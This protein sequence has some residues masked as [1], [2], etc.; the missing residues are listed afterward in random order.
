M[1]RPGVSKSP[2][3]EALLMFCLL[4]GEAQEAAEAVRFRHATCDRF[5]RC[6]LSR[7]L[8]DAPPALRR[9]TLPSR[10]FPSRECPALGTCKD[11]RFRVLR[12]IPILKPTHTLPSASALVAVRQVY[13][14]YL[15]ATLFS[16]WAYLYVRILFISTTIVFPFC[17]VILRARSYT[18]GV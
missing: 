4:Q 1:S 14:S 9:R 13:V 18:T 5:H 17:F 11:R 3:R 12:M 7:R 10:P 6:S 8:V 16:P 15:L 2:L